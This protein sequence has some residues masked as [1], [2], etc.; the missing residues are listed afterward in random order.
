M[1][2]IISRFPGMRH[3]PFPLSITND[4]VT[5]CMVP[6]IMLEDL[7]CSCDRRKTGAFKERPEKITSR[8]IDF[9][10]TFSHEVELRHSIWKGK[11]LQVYLVDFWRPRLH[12]QAWS[13][14]VLFFQWMSSALPD[15]GLSGFSCPS[16]PWIARVEGGGAIQGRERDEN[17]LRSV[18]EL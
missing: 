17:P 9:L 13:P 7:T 10:S 5:G 1:A 4:I 11:I 8:P 12:S 14:T 6:I 2:T 15:L 16:L 18:A 3:F